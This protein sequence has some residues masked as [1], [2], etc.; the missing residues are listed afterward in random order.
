MDGGRTRRTY[1]SYDIF[2]K[3]QVLTESDLAGEDKT[4]WRLSAIADGEYGYLR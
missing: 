1:N 2:M 4:V 3:T